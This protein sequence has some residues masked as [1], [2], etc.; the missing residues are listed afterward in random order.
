MKIMG[1]NV[2]SKTLS[3]RQNRL[4][5]TVHQRAKDS[6]RNRCIRMHPW[7]WW[8]RI[9]N[10]SDHVT[11]FHFSNS[12]VHLSVA[13]AVDYVWR[14]TN[15]GT[16]FGCQLPKCARRTERWK[17]LTDSLLLFLFVIMAD[18]VHRSR[19][20]MRAKFPYPLESVCLRCSTSS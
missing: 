9:R 16:C 17:T 4:R 5:Q 12:D 13:A 2:L 18:A 15:A 6:I 11:F 1:L 14:T 7:T 19:W 3:T 10:S 8:S 20:N